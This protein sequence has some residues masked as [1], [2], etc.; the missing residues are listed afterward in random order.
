MPTAPPR[1]RPAGAVRTAT[2]GSRRPAAYR[3]AAATGGP[4]RRRLMI[5]RVLLV[6]ALAVAMGK[7]IVVQTVQAGELTEAS[8]RQATTKIKLPAT[9]GSI[10][11]R[12]GNVLAFSVEARALVANPR[13]IAKDKG[14]EAAAY[15]TAMANAVAQA[16]GGDPAALGELLSADRPY[17]VLARLVDPGVADALREQFPEI[18]AERREDRQ[19]PAGDTAA[20]IIGAASWSADAKK[21]TGKI[22]LESSQNTLL[23]G[24]DGERIVDTAEGSNAVIPGSTR[25]E[26]PA[27]QG[28]D[29]QLTL[30]SD[31]QYT[32]QQAL[33]DYVA[34]HGAKLDSS[35]VVLDAKTAEVLAIANGQSFDPGE[36]GS[37]TAAQ[38]AN[39]AVSSPFEPGSVNKVVTMAAALEYGLATPDDVLAVPG[40][41]KV[42][43]TTVSDAW[44]HATENYTLTGVLAKS[45]NVG[46]LM[47]AREV[48]EDRFVDMLGRFG[49]GQRTGV[50]L[51]GESPG[52]VPPRESWSASTFGNLP[53]GQGLSMTTLQMAGMFQTIANDG[54]RIPPRVIEST[55]GPDG[56]RTTPEPPAPVQVV[57]PQTAET[58]RTMLTAVTQDARGGQRGTGYLAAVPGYQVAG[59]TG[60]AQQVDADCKCYVSGRYWITFA[61]MLPAQDPRFVVAIMLD[62]PAGGT[63]A[64]PLF[65]QIASY[66]A[67]REQLP[68]SVEPQPIQT[69]VVP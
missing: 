42:A 39:P 33:T 20:N 46:T 21:V 52:S 65:H 36:F 51:P 35:V 18:A 49:V 13:Q 48:G 34:Q 26:R 68:V 4:Y 41:I 40:S 47:T 7:L 5:G 12:D 66:L 37:A 61:G 44:N 69:L 27:V 10:T 60:T 31:L 1:P 23:T 24:S 16:T 67:Q 25:Y 45:S 9:R 28:S 14:P 29:I 11:D 30:D 22:G 43:D 17:V 6:I 55:T 59:K 56:V 50:G 2:N 32:V 15:V 19:Y 53:I 54:V 3:R 57:S 63:S 38:Q 8:A 58:L 64:A 62:A